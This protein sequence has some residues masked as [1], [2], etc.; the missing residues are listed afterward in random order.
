MEHLS[1]S[2]R[3]FQ[4]ETGAFLPVFFLL[5]ELEIAT[6]ASSLLCLLDNRTQDIL[7]ACLQN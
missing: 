2:Y 1:G 3:K 4:S 5:S 7:Q 6:N